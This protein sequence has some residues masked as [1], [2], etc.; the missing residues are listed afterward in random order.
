[1]GW[2]NLIVVFNEIH[3]VAKSYAN[4]VNYIASF[5]KPIPPTNIITNNTILTQYSINQELEV[6]GKKG[7]AALRK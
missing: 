1:M 5:V 6:F 3:S 7:E 4:V 2:K